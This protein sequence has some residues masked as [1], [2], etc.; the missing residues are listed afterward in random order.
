MNQEPKEPEYPI[1]QSLENTRHESKPAISNQ[2]DPLLESRDRGP[3]ATSSAALEADLEQARSERRTERFPWILL[4][5]ILADCILFKFE[6]S[7]APN[8]FIGLLSLVLLVGCAR[9]LDL[10]W[11]AIYFDRMFNRLIGNSSRA[12]REASDEEL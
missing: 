12:V 5:T 2:I 8:T 11:V 3:S 9:W 7:W 10:P 1:K 6:N 4:S